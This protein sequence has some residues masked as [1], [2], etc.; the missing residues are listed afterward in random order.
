MRWLLLSAQELELQAVLGRRAL[1]LAAA[2]V[3]WAD[4]TCHSS[5]AHELQACIAVAAREDVKHECRPEA[6]PS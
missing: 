2:K 1:L 4:E 6:R 3:R 5:D